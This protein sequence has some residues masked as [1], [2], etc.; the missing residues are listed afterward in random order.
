MTD[1]LKTDDPLHVYEREVSKVHPLDSAEE[2]KC[3]AHMRASDQ[4]ADTARNRLV[5]AHLGRVIALAKT[6]ENGRI[7]LLELVECGNA[8]LMAAAE[9]LV[10]FDHGAFWDFAK[11]FVE[12]SL[13]NVFVSRS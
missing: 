3:L 1:V 6:Y 5:E 13:E 10:H 12:R 8:A 7:H 9:D 4:M 2:A 11:P